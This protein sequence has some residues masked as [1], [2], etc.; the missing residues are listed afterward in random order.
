MSN[1]LDFS[2]AELRMMVETCCEPDCVEPRNGGSKWC[3]AH[4]KERPVLR[5]RFR[6]LKERATINKEQFN[7]SELVRKIEARRARH[8][9]TG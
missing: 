7:A 9:S 8:R 2:N 1:P 4:Q 5:R 6:R 3:K